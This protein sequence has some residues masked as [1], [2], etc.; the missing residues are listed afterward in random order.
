VIYLRV[1]EFRYISISGNVLLPTI[2]RNLF[3][4]KNL[5]TILYIYSGACVKSYDFESI[6][7]FFE[8]VWKSYVLILKSIINWS[9]VISST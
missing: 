3:L 4:V 9:V 6:Q 8:I 1:N 7:T 5:S 2:Y